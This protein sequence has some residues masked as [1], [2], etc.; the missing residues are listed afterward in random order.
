MSRISL[1]T[2]AAVA[3]LGAAALLAG[4][5]Q[6][7]QI[8]DSNVPTLGTNDFQ[9]KGGSVDWSYFGSSFAA[10]LRGTLVLNNASG[11]CARMRV[12]SLYQGPIVDTDYG[13]KVCAPDGKKHEWSVLI[14][15]VPTEDIDNVKVSIETKTASH[16]WAI[17]D[18]AYSPPQPPSDK[19]RLHSSD[20]DF[21]DKYWSSITSETSGSGTVYWNRAD[22]AAYTPRLM[23]TLWVDNGACARMHLTYK[24]EHGGVLAD[25]YG[26]P[27]CPT[28]FDLH[29][30]TIDLSPYTGAYIRSVTV[31]IQTQEL[32]N[33]PWAD[34]GSSYAET[35]YIDE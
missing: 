16:D 35:V 13:G 27:A 22:G 34:I 21:G 1:S 2:F 17:L 30:Y 33:G 31:N 4:A 14:P 18:S 28:D 23:G 7:E 20:V 8:D 29:S 11:S 9:F 32:H 15:T 19:V 5:A 12:D 10:E 6:A 26:G 25:K 3:V 24:D